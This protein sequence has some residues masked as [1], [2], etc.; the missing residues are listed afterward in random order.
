MT[1]YRYNAR[2]R[3]HR[4]FNNFGKEKNPNN[5]KFYAKN[6]GYAEEYKFIYSYGEIWYE[7][8]LEVKEINKDDINL[9]NLSENFKE[10]K[11]YKKYISDEYNVRL[12]DYTRFLNE[13]TDNS[14]RKM[15]EDN[16]KELDNLEEELTEKLKKSEFQMLS[17]FD[18]Q[19]VLLDELKSLG[20]NG[21]E[22]KNE[23][24]L[25]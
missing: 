23:I 20:F 12:R 25:F 16:I 5:F 1:L 19:N 8:E 4:K 14:S 3:S 11:A 24:A 7:C 10:T 18:L 2:E 6:M 9:F 21:Y 22:T 17:D 13:A 15:W